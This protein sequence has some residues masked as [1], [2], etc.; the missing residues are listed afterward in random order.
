MK[1]PEQA[2]LSRLKVDEV[3][4]FAWQEECWGE[5]WGMAVNVF[6]GMKM[7]K[8][9]IVVMSAQ[10]HESTKNLWIEIGELY[11]MLIISQYS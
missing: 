8:N 10:P 4:S 5:C 11:G 6:G 3:L 9:Q 7:F 1:C 2:K